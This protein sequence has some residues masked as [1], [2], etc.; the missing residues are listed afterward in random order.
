MSALEKSQ[1]FKVCSVSNFNPDGNMLY[2]VWENTDLQKKELRI[3]LFSL[4]SVTYLL[5]WNIGGMHGTSPI[6][7]VF[8]NDQ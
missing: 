8:N 2:L 7:I 4:K 1:E 5:L 6:S 3:S